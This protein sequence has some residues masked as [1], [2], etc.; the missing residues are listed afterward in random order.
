MGGEASK[1]E[2]ESGFGGEKDPAAEGAGGDQRAQPASTQHEQGDGRSAAGDGRSGGESEQSAEGCATASPACVVDRTD[3]DELSTASKQDSPSGKVG[4]FGSLR[5][6]L[7]GIVTSKAEEQ[8]DSASHIAQDMDANVIVNEHGANTN[9]SLPMPVDLNPSTQTVDGEADTGVQQGDFNGKMNKDERG[10]TPD[11]LEEDSFFDATED[12]GLSN[13]TLDAD[14]SV[15]GE[16]MTPSTQINTDESS[17]ETSPSITNTEKFSHLQIERDQSDVGATC[18]EN[19]SSR[20]LP[21]ADKP[22][23]SDDLARNSSQVDSLPAANLMIPDQ[24]P[25]LGGQHSEPEHDQENKM[26]RALEVSPAQ[27][28]THSARVEADVPSDSSQNAN[29]DSV[30]ELS[31]D[32][33]PPPHAPESSSGMSSGD[34]A[35]QPGTRL[36]HLPSSPATSDL[37]SAQHS[38][39]D[40]EGKDADVVSVEG[41]RVNQTQD[42]PPSAAVSEEER[43]AGSHEVDRDGGATTSSSLVTDYQVSGVDTPTEHPAANKANMAETDNTLNFEGDEEVRVPKGSYNMDF[44]DKLD[45]PNFNPFQSRSQVGQGK[46]NTTPK[47]SGSATE[48]QDSVCNNNHTAGSFPKTHL[49]GNTEH[50]EPPV[51]SD[52]AQSGVIG[53]HNNADL[54]T[55]EANAEAPLAESSAD[56][57]KCHKASNIHKLGA[58]N[59]EG[60]PRSGAHGAPDTQATSEDQQTGNKDHSCSPAGPAQVNAA[61]SEELERSESAEYDAS[62]R[63]KDQPEGAVEETAVKEEKTIALPPDGPNSAEVLTNSGQQK[64]DKEP[65]E[66]DIMQPANDE[67][68]NLVRHDDSLAKSGTE[69]D[70]SETF[71]VRPTSDAE[72]TGVG[73]TEAQETSGV[74]MD[75]GRKAQDEK[76][77]ESQEADI[78][79][80]KPVE[81]SP[82][83]AADSAVSVSAGV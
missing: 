16:N 18:A 61:C 65:G 72:E 67:N 82:V 70:T 79:E 69:I 52:I 60:L 24:K 50:S 11:V 36:H 59:S 81:H 73:V 6:T 47:A 29:A 77:E 41:M 43:S 45:D 17:R 56:K 76:A 3:G 33:Q 27:P 32:A 20:V 10:T 23:P 71:I 14:A 15:F 26:Q 12:T 83:P 34:S 22:Q 75:S 53:A 2:E 49:K 1:E 46:E 7:S 62:P 57:D 64:V 9:G 68:V 5:Q 78:V 51:L 21:A 25:D 63:A 31:R 19:V 80:T 42:G 66:N 35:G 38:Q 30:A 40:D 44:L 39:H 74:T 4:L 54:T 8:S 28:E 55:V 48:S 37:D 58:S 13:V